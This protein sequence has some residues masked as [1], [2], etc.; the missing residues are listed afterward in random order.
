MKNIDKSLLRNIS[1]TNRYYRG[2]TDYVGETVNTINKLQ[3]SWL[4]MYMFVENFPRSLC[5]LSIYNNSIKCFLFSVYQKPFS[6]INSSVVAVHTEK[7]VCLAYLF[8]KLGNSTFILRFNFVFYEFFSISGRHQG[9][10]RLYWDQA[11][12]KKLA[13]SWMH[14][15]F[16]DMSF[17]R[18]TV[19]CQDFI[20]Y[21]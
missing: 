16:L 20:I 19:Y 7:F 13:L 12:I 4:Y 8:L 9:S 18:S 17:K 3:K 2:S 1:L 14:P 10:S 21:Y 5:S 15:G 11:F 6:S